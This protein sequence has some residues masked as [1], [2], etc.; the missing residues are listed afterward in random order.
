MLAEFTGQHGSDSGEA[1]GYQDQTP[2]IV[3]RGGRDVIGTERHHGL[4]QNQPC[5]CHGAD[6]TFSSHYRGGG[7]PKI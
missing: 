6:P 4:H 2:G 7:T 3:F 5:Q 1:D